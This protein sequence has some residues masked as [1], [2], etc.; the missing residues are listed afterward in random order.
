MELFKCSLSGHFVRDC[1]FKKKKINKC[2]DCELTGHF[3]KDCPNM[4]C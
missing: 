1:P 3:T 4:L 2:F